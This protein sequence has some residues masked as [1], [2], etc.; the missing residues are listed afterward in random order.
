MEK[1]RGSSLCQYFMKSLLTSCCAGVSG[2]TCLGHLGAGAAWRR[3][4]AGD[5]GPAGTPRWALPGAA[6]LD[7]AEVASAGVAGAAGADEKV[8]AK[9]DA[10]V[11][12]SG[13]ALP[14][15]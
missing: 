13:L 6:P 9:G 2:G 3:E 11:T 4:D 10:I 8:E 1:W 7:S 14:G 5:D 15:W 12:R